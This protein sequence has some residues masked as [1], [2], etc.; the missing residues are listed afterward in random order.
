MTNEQI[1]EIRKH[2]YIVLRGPRGHRY[3]EQ[4]IND[5]MHAYFDYREN[6]YGEIVDEVLKPKEEQK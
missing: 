5:L 2:G 1:D 3:T 4:E 6:N